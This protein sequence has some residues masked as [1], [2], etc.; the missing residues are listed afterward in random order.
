MGFVI[1]RKIMTYRFVRE[2]DAAM[3]LEFF[4]TIVGETDNLACSKAE[5]EEMTIEEEKSFLKNMND[6]GSF[7]IVA[8]SEKCICGSCDIRIQNRE[9]LRHRAEMG[10][11]V[12]KEYWGTG[13]AQR[14][15]EESI[16]EARNRGVKKISLTVRADNERAKAFYRRNGFELSGID[17]MLFCI[18]GIYIDGEQYELLLK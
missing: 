10:I 17:R 15:L 18:A 1:R 11:A 13:V 12:R 4:K 9:R 8:I 7:S 2:E 14:I 16:S 6:S 5:A 3:Y